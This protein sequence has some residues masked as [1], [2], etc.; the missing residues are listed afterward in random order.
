MNNVEKTLYDSL[1]SDG[2]DAEEVMEIIDDKTY[3]YWNDL[4]SY[5]YDV[6][7]ADIE[8]NVDTEIAEILKSTIDFEKLGNLYLGFLGGVYVFQSG[9]YVFEIYD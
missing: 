5:G 6:F 9:K 8:P 2:Y 4:A 7:Y 1:I 3:R